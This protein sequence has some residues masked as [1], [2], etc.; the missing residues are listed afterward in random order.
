MLQ[1]GFSFFL[2]FEEYRAI[3]THELKD[4]VGEKKTCNMLTKTFEMAREKYPE[5]FRNANWDGNG[6]LLD[7]GSL[8]CQRMVANAWT[9]DP[10][11]RDITMDMALTFLMSLRFMAIE[12]G[13]GMGFKNKLRV[14]LIQWV[15]EKGESATREG[16]EIAPFRRLKNYLS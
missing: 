6:N 2:L 9:F 12:K 11:K 3:L 7:D 13:L 14:R 5:V 8:N 10:T 15:T 16:K 1:K 4:V